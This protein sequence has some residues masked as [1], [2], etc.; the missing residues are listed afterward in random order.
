MT[1]IEK[2]VSTRPSLNVGSSTQWRGVWK[3][4]MAIAQRCAI[5]TLSLFAVLACMCVLLIGQT[6]LGTGSIAGTILDPSGNAVSDVA[7]TVVNHETGQERR[8]ITTGSGTFQIPVLP[9][10]AYDIVVEKDGFSR[11]ESKDLQ[12]TVGSTVTVT[13]KLQIG[14]V[15]ATVDVV[16]EGVAVDTTQTSEGSLIDRNEIDNLPING[17]RYDQFALL[18]AGVT[19][20]SRVGLLSVHGVAGVFNNFTVEG[21]DDNQALFSEARGRTRIAGSISAN[22]IDQFQVPTAG[23]LPEYGRT[24]GGGVNTQVR[25]GGSQLHVD[26]F[27]YFRDSAMSALDPIA[28]ASGALKTYEQRQQFGGSIGGAIVP[29][30][31]FFFVNYDQQIRPFPLL[32]SDTSN[33]LTTGLPAQPTAQ[34]LA[35]FNAG[36]AFLRAEFPNGAPNNTIP[37]TFNQQSPLEKVDWTIN[38]KNTLSVMYNYLRWSNINAIQTPAVLGNVGRNGTDDARIHSLNFRLTT[39]LQ[40]TLVN[41][42]RFQWGRDFE[43]EF[44]NMSGPQVTVGGFSYGTATFLPRPAYPDER[45]TQVVDNLSKIA[46]SHSFKFGFELSRAYDILN[47]PANFAGSYSYS[48]ALAFGQDLLNP[49]SHSYTNYQQSFG[50]PGL[51]F[52]TNDWALFAQDQ[53]KLRRNLT[54]NYGLRWDFQQMPAVVHPNPAI[55]TTESLNETFTNFG[56][57]TGLAWDIAGNGKTVLRASYAL[58]YGRTSNGILFNALTQ[59]GLIDPT[60]S[61]ISITAQ[62]TDAFAPTFPNVLS[63][64]PASATGSVSAFRLAS[65]FASPRVQEINAG[66]TR[67]LFS[68]TTISV[69]Y[70]RTYADR[71]PATI[72]SNLPAPQFQRSYQL[73]DGSNFTVPF[74]A[75]VI[76]TAAGQT[77]NVNLARPNPNFGAI[78][79]NT[80]IAQ[81]WYNALLVEVKR[82]LS[83]GLSG[84]ITYTLAKA[85][86]TTG[87]GDGGGTGTEGPFGGANFQDQFNRAANKGASPLDQR[88]RA[89]FFAVYQLARLETGNPVGNALVN[90]WGI[91]TIFTAE[92]GRPYS[93]GIS[94]GNLQFLGTDG[95]VY[96][97]FGGLRGQGSS[98]DRNIVPTLGRDSVYGDKNYR[99]DLRISR[100]FHA[101]EKLRMEIL[102]E[103]FNILNRAN[104]NGYNSTLFASTATTATTPLSQAVPLVQ[105]NNYGVANND[106][107]QP[108]GTNARRL[109]VSLRLKF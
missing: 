104:Y 45:R 68:G 47:N 40:P 24:A 93:P 39:T 69:S 2:L 36:A 65:D 13:L 76:R 17:R 109:Q 6:Q 64:L 58:L 3:Q 4:I 46:G 7:V 71:L 41:E 42:A 70:V 100:S 56:P 83:N 60:Q 74:S 75:G 30:K 12:V 18:A 8:T 91:S 25:S 23:F 11:L 21:N 72:D 78:T 99:L 22:A 98:S 51:N 34:Q 101:T 96:N 88:H 79:L 82:R 48:N 62:P 31:L 15:S 77:V 57:R 63:S 97:G 50:L 102:G 94:L 20:D 90:G 27:Y 107:S 92:T 37:R 26:A 33:V 9:A 80:S 108:D 29:N 55:P 43:Y 32:T 106:G 105:Q 59:T 10:A 16:A 81:S 1:K 5:R 85:E 86:S 54:F 28:K 14:A 53:W 73:P 49:A 35:A 19:R 84:G 95:A 44:Q 103:G 38:Q 67:E 52:G 87:T 61:T 66:I 89:N